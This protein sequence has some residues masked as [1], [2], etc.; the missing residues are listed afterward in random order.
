MWMYVQ[1]EDKGGWFPLDDNVKADKKDY[2]HRTVYAYS[3]DLGPEGDYN[4]VRQKGPLAFDIDYKAEEG[5]IPAAI[6]AMK[7][8]F[9]TLESWDLNP[10][11]VNLWASG[12][13]GFHVEIPQKFFAPDKAQL[14]LNKFH[15]WMAAKMSELADVKLDMG[16]YA[17]RHM[18]RCPGQRSDGRWKVPVSALEIATMTEE[19]YFRICSGP[20]GEVLAAQRIVPKEYFCPGLAQQWS[21]AVSVAKSAMAK[22]SGSITIDSKFL[23]VFSDDRIPHCVE[24]MRDAADVT[25]N[26]NDVS[27]QFGAFVGNAA[28]LSEGFRDKLMLEFARAYK[29]DS[30]STLNQKLAHTKG[31]VG[32]AVAGNFSFSCAGCRKVLS[33][34]PCNGCPVQEA[35]NEA[36]QEVSSIVAVQEGFYLKNQKGEG[37]RLTN[38]TMLKSQSICTLERGGRMLQADAVD[39]TSRERGKEVQTRITIPSEDWVSLAAFKK[40]I[41]KAP[42]ALVLT[43]TEAIL[44]LLQIYLDSLETGEVIMQVDKLGIHL[45]HGEEGEDD[46]A[47]WVEAGWSLDDQGVSAN[48]SYEGFAA[49]SALTLR[50]LPTPKGEKDY[51]AADILMKL[52]DSNKPEAVGHMLGWAASC[53]LKEHL[54]RIGRQEFPLLHISGLRGSGKTSTAVIYAT[55]TGTKLI[56]GPM[57]V[58]GGTTSPVRQALSQTT[59]VARVFDEFNKPSLGP[60][61]YQRILSFLKAAYFRQNLAIGF[62]GK[63]KVGDVGAATSNEIATSPVIYM[64][65]ETTDSE[66]LL[67]RS[68]VIRI[69]E[70]VHYEGKY[71][72]NFQDVYLSLSDPSPNGHPLQRL[73][74]LLV[75]AALK[76]KPD[77]CRE[78]YQEAQKDLPLDKHSRTINNLFVIRM[79]LKFLASALIGFPQEVLDRL[80][81]LDKIVVAS[82]QEEETREQKQRT[83]GPAE[84]ML[85]RL[86]EMAGILEDDRI[87][88]RL[89][90]GHYVRE[91]S[92]LWISSVSAF[93][94]YIPY[95]RFMA[96]TDREVSSA[97]AILAMFKEA[98]YFLGEMGPPARPNAKG[99]FCLDLSQL[100]GLEI[101]T[102]TFTAI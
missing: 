92:K 1:Y 9:K 22:Q 24:L 39:I 45:Q 21:Q 33:V 85:M 23:D 47:V 11:Y 53:H 37:T 70:A 49:N 81:E 3:E 55:L 31:I 102:D 26:Y 83:F 82:W 80:A 44:P 38:F 74:R 99:W 63:T 8:I 16:L 71:K 56:G 29:S 96:Y 86:S 34:N 87:P 90:P 94:H 41:Q 40:T 52:M 19:E 61:K 35:K 18:L 42:G 62:I 98:P 73:C 59:T 30:R 28:K 65:K 58:D 100:E 64:S 51:E 66:E 17:S 12:G 75:Q 5:G 89:S 78:W 97:A 10:E 68:I 84:K 72:E 67:Q 20:R 48:Y 76:T 36:A 50:G 32:A 69:T 93:Q 43:G 54:F 91:G 79:G 2:K 15:N 27:M 7:R 101:N 25:G 60:D 14:H 77:E 88:G 6:E 95:N 13:K 46:K 57:V 4:T